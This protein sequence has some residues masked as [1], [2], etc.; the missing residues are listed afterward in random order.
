MTWIIFELYAHNPPFLTLFFTRHEY[1]KKNHDVY[2]LLET[3]L[4]VDTQNKMT[5]PL[6]CTQVVSL[7]RGLSTHCMVVWFPVGLLV[8]FGSDSFWTAALT[9]SGELYLC[10]VHAVREQACRACLWKGLSAS[11]LSALLSTDIQSPSSHKHLP[12]TGVSAHCP[13]LGVGVD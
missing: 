2:L 1:W 4:F 5:L 10:Q 11:L 3:L 13:V 6:L 12:F 9:K 8:C 7:Q